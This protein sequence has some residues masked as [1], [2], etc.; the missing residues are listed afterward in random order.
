[1]TDAELK[2]KQGL[3]EKAVKD[4]ET[5]YEQRKQAIEK[6]KVNNRLAETP[7]PEEKPS[8]STDA[9]SR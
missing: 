1:M 6:Q 5:W 4:L 7:E 9:S 2:I 3:R 8:P